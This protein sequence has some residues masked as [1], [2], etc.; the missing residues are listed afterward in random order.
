MVQIWG[1]Y[2]N[3]LP[4][5]FGHPG[6]GIDILYKIIKNIMLIIKLLS[7]HGS[8]PINR[9]NVF[10]ANFLTCLHRDMKIKKKGIY[11]FFLLPPAIFDHSNLAI[12]RWGTKF[13]RYPYDQTKITTIKWIQAIQ[14]KP[15][16]W[17]LNQNN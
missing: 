5:C 16:H 13:K 4:Q 9:Q 14:P 2:P 8:K 3:C 6:R 12:Q 15:I 7:K 1:K 11:D 17:I 10:I